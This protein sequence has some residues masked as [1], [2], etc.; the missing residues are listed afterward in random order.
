M[1][2]ALTL[3]A[4]TNETSGTSSLAVISITPVTAAHYPVVF[5]IRPRASLYLCT[6]FTFSPP[7]DDKWHKRRTLSLHSQV[8]HSTFGRW[9]SVAAQYLWNELSMEHLLCAEILKSMIAL[10][11]HAN[12][13]NYMI[14]F[15]FTDDQMEAQKGQE[16][17]P[18][19]L[20]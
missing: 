18:R 4:P 5:K 1:V 3:V 19:P 9:N 2:T 11:P 16:V 20:I 17:C 10:F 14:I 7:L 12:R 8:T 6:W 13:K 15:H